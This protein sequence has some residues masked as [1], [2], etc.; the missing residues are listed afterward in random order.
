MACI[1]IRERGYETLNV[2][3]SDGGTTLGRAKKNT[4][5]LKNKFVS[6][7]HCEI[8][9]KGGKSTIID[10]ESTNGLFVNGRRVKK[11]KLEDGDKILAG[12]ALII[13]VSD[14]DAFSLED[15]IARR[16]GGPGQIAIS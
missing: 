11:K 15:S 14:E 6:G 4:I 12:T 1:I 8:R 13:Y 7:A 16:H 9:H 5:S 10:L 3:L 2:P